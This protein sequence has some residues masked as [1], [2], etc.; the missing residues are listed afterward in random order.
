MIKLLT[1]DDEL[2]LCEFMRDFFSGIGYQV[3]IALTG[4]EALAYVSRE[5]PNIVFL[6]IIMPDISGL[7]V[8]RRIKEIDPAVKVIMVS[9]ADDKEVKEKAR[10]LGADE[11][12]RKPFSRRYLEDVVI[13]K[14]IELTK[15]QKEGAGL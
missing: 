8:L 7:E 6:D 11:F 5:R 1:V 14:I 15:P 3:G 4:E 13:R 9:A 2:G 10:V 12:I